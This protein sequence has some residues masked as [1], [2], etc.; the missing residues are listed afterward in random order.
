MQSSNALMRFSYVYVC[1]AGGSLIKCTPE[2]KE[3]AVVDYC[4]VTKTLTAIT[5]SNSV[6]PNVIIGWK[7]KYSSYLGEISPEVENIINIHFRAEKPNEKW[8]TDI[9]E[10]WAICLGSRKRPHPR[11]I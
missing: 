6:T 7:K 3:Q 2:Q 4:T 5:K 10:S 8:L 9:T 11:V 1:E